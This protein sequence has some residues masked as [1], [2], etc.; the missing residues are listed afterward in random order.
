M[1]DSEARGNGDLRLADGLNYRMGELK[2][3]L[4]LITHG[5]RYVTATGMKM[6]LGLSADS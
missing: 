3:S 6:M 2:Y 5:A 4:N 1:Y